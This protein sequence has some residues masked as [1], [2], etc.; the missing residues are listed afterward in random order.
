MLQ[1][2]IEGAERNAHV[3]QRAIGGKIAVQ[4]RS[5]SLRRPLLDRS[6]AFTF[7]G[8]QFGVFRFTLL[9]GCYW[10]N[11][12]AACRSGLLR[13]LRGSFFDPG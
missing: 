13:S 4:V 12:I 6:S 7:V 2:S 5:L 3:E 9:G 11:I 10:V 8:I 1:K